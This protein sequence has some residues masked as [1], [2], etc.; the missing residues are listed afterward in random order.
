MVGGTSSSG[1]S[2][3]CSVRGRYWISS[4][5]SVRST[6][7]PGVTAMLRPTS[8]AEESTISGIRGAVARSRSRLT[9]PRTRLTP[10][11]SMAALAD[12]GLTSGRLLGDSA[13]MR[14]SAANRTRLS[15]RQS[16]AASLTSCS[17]VCPAA[18]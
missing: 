7:A 18:R 3:T 13:S 6:T 11:V 16:S 9:P 5:T 1:T 15:S 2:R 10:P 8:N 17:A 4:N 14:F 12:A